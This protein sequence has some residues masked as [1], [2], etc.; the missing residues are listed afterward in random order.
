MT[1]IPRLIAFATAAALVG[2]APADREPL[3][4]D[5]DAQFVVLASSSDGWG[6]DLVLLDSDGLETG[7][8]ATD[9]SDAND[10]AYHPDGFFVVSAADG[11]NDGL[12]RVELDGT[13]REFGE[14]GHDWF[15]VPFSEQ[16]PY[17]VAVTNTGDVVVSEAEGGV[18]TYDADGEEITTDN[19]DGANGDAN[20]CFM[21]TSIAVDGTTVSMDL[22][23]PRVVVV[24]PDGS[25]GQLG[26]VFGQDLGLVSADAGGDWFAASFKDG[27]SLWQLPADGTEAVEVGRISDLAADDTWAI[28]GMETA[29][30][31][32][33]YLLTEGGAGSAIIEVDGEGI[34][35][36]FATGGDAHW[37][38]FT[39]VHRISAAA[40]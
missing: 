27:D 33:V 35:V 39:R 9:I 10:I 12:Y 19:L 36:P 11:M 13:A 31:D 8:V 32:S 23:G 26:D 2:C 16:R 38:A 14:S 3:V 22:Y 6:K 37:T 29:G 25:L 4:V 28:D 20:S 7:R 17:G 21:D 15:G 5:Q 18:S 34:V 1:L 40:L 24:G 30:V